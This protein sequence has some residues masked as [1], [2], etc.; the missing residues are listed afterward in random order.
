MKRFAIFSFKTDG[1]PELYAD[2]NLASEVERFEQM[3][4]LVLAWRETSPRQEVAGFQ[5]AA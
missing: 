4:Y 1:R 5:K 2:T 3:G